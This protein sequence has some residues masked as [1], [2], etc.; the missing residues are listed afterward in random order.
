[1]AQQKSSPS[2]NSLSTINNDG[3]RNF[4]HPA[5]VSGKWTLLRRISAVILIAVYILLPWIKI[6]G[7]PA[8]FLDIAHRRFHFFGLTIVQQDLWMGFFLITGLGFSLYFVT[9]LFGRLWCGWACPQ[10]VFLEHVYRRIERWIEGDATK[11][12]KLDKMKLN[13]GNKLLKRG[14]KQVIFVLV[15]AVIAHVFLSYFVSLPRL[16]EM[17]KHD[18]AENWYAFVFVFIFTAILYFNFAW[19]REQLC[20]IIC[21]YGRFQSALLDQHSMVIGYDEIRGEPRGKKGQSTGD[22][23]DCNRCVSV[24]PTGIDIRNGLQIECIGC[25]N[26]IDACNSIMR[27]VGKPEGLIRYD[28]Q[29]G[30]EGRK[31]QWLRPRIILYSILLLIGVTVAGYSFSSMESA[32]FH[33]TRMPGSPYIVANDLVRNQYFMRI[34]NKTNEPT[35]YQLAVDTNQPGIATSGFNGFVELG[36][37]QEVKQPLIVTVP[38]QAYQGE[39]VIGITLTDKAG[40]V[41]VDQEV[42]FLGPNPE[43][44][45]ARKSNGEQ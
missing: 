14:L 44:L 29:E 5:D 13:E 3:S 40:E 41:S 24:C 33:A 28:S 2:I 19:F 31:T 39:F 43:L 17:I 1:M 16:Y 23:I 9:S 7:F 34:I 37:M 21:P 30:L 15:S 45:H 32:T 10:T 35:Q 18:P 42:N 26:C 4:L 6:G 8:V 27:K 20:I 36:P 22:C 11:R 38:V 12:K 25:A